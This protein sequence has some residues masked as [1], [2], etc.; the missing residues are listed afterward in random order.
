LLACYDQ[1]SD[2]YQS[3]CKIGTGF[4]DDMLEKLTEQLSPTVVESMP[5]FY[6][7]SEKPDV[8]L[9]ESQVWE[10]KAADLSISPV[11]FAAY[12]LVDAGKGVALRFPR[13]LKIREDK[14]PTDATTAQQVADM[15]KQQALAL[16]PS[17]AAED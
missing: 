16:A 8:W 9:T 14:G 12:G 7:T 11:H 13:F 5:P 4:Q 10:I 1:D 6:R 3:I 15:Y 2:E 17:M